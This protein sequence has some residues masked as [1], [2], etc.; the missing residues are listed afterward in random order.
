MVD[1]P[2]NRRQRRV[3]RRHPDFDDPTNNPPDVEPESLDSIIKDN[4]SSIKGSMYQRRFQDILNCR[5]LRLDGDEEPETPEDAFM[6]VW[7]LHDCTFKVNISF[8]VILRH[9]TSDRLRYYHASSNNA[10]VFPLAVRVSSREEVN[11][12]LQQYGGIDHASLGLSQRT[13]SAWV[14]YRVT[15]VTF[16][17]YKLDGVNRIG[18]SAELPKHINDSKSILG[19]KTSRQR[20]GLW[21]DNLCFFRCMAVD[22][23]LDTDSQRLV[24]HP[25][26]PSPHQQVT[27]RLLRHWLVHTNNKKDATRFPGV[28]LEDLWELESLFDISIKVFDLHENKTSSVVWSSGNNRTHDLNLNIY[29]NHFSLITDVATYCRTFICKTCSHCFTTKYRAIAH[30]CESSECVHFMFRGSSYTKKKTVFDR[31]KDVGIHI[32]KEKTYYPYRIT[33]DIETYLNRESVPPPTD[34]CTYE[35]LHELMSVSVCSNVPSFQE[36]QCFVSDGDKEKLVRRFVKYLLAI[37]KKAKRAMFIKYRRYREKL[38]VLC[39]NFEACEGLSD[40]KGLVGSARGVWENRARLAGLEEELDTYLSVIPVVSF[41]GQ[42]YDINVK[43][44]KG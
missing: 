8:G 24:Q 10:T 2:E 5:L 33:F 27:L 25:R 21:N 32:P 19:L 31:L 23:H 16:Y 43:V 14:L 17:I 41:N 20:P 12:L 26:Q 44:K 34:N 38:Q 7:G 37:A 42:K 15:N 6:R 28:V 9:T 40:T 11:D 30:R 35:A 22:Y 36:P 13:N 29:E 18:T 3:L 4:W 1:R 39:N